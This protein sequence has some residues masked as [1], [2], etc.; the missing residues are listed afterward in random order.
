MEFFVLSETTLAIVWCF[1][2][3]P[4]LYPEASQQAQA[5]SLAWR[6][7]KHTKTTLVY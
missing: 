1:I 3:W 4:M 7:V 2:V 6:N 5:I